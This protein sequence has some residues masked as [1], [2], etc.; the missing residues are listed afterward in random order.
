MIAKTGGNRCFGNKPKALN[1][2]IDKAH[3]QGIPIVLFDSD[4]P[5]S[6]ASTYI[7]TNN[8]EA[9]AVAARRMA[10]FL[11]GKGETA[12]ITQPQQYN[13]QER[14][15]GF[16]QTIKQKYPNMKVAAVLDGKGDELTSKK[17]RRR[18]WRKIRPSKEFSRLKPMERAAWPVL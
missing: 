2:V 16:E 15:K 9:G 3:E 7:G 12:V 5:L 13:H 18:F 11:N 8:M 17:K 1:P 10:E 14:T 4:A 6:K